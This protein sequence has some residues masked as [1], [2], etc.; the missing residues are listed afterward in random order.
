MM[1]LLLLM[2]I[3]RAGRWLLRVDKAG[4]GGVQE[5]S[6]AEPILRR[7]R[8]A[9]PRAWVGEDGAFIEDFYFEL[10]LD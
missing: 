10:A 5:G 3:Y 7:E 8:A 4:H 1:A 9:A 2:V 6:V